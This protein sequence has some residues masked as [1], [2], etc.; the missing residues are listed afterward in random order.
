MHSGIY[1]LDCKKLKN[2]AV[3][4]LSN[5]D[6]RK[7]EIYTLC[8]YITSH[9]YRPFFENPEVFFCGV[10]DFLVFFMTVENM[11]IYL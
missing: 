10:V 3:K 6:Q 8:V 11:K 5:T 2:T 1:Y 9:R 7:D 4:L